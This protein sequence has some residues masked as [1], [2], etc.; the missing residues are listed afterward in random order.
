M[1]PVSWLSKTRV[2]GVFAT[3][4][5]VVGSKPDVDAPTGA[6][7]VV[8]APAPPDAPADGDPPAG[9]EAAAL[10]TDDDAALG[11]ADDDAPGLPDAPA[12]AAGDADAGA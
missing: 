11:A 12:D 4:S 3:A 9:A 5:S 6:V 2:K 8:L 10:G 1:T 7:T